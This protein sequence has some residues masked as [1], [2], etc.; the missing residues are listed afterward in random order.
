M[1]FFKAVATIL[2]TLA[3]SLALAAPDD[4]FWPSARSKQAIFTELARRNKEAYEKGIFVI[5]YRWQFREG[6]SYQQYRDAFSEYL[7][8]NED[9]F[10]HQNAEVQFKGMLDL[11]LW[12]V[13]PLIAVQL[14]GDLFAKPVTLR[15][16]QSIDFRASSL[17]I[18]WPRPTTVETEQFNEKIRALYDGIS[19]PKD[20][21]SRNRF[22][23]VSSMNAPVSDLGFCTPTLSFKKRK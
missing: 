14:V 18:N 9:W 20:P 1:K 22:F 6:W 15:T 8:N 10:K 12:E 21:E 5:K 16:S 3:T 11:D 7:L 17:G 23:V 19:I 13:P 4:F 2:L